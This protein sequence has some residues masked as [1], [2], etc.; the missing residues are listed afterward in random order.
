MKRGQ[1]HPR[2]FMVSFHY[3]LEI[4][5]KDTKVIGLLISV[6]TVG[7]QTGVNVSVKPWAQG[8]ND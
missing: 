7:S 1:Q 6:E 5:V 3:R 8:G 4:I 2:S